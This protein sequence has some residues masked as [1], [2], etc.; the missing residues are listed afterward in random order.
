MEAMNALSSIKWESDIGFSWSDGASGIVSIGW[1]DAWELSGDSDFQTKIKKYNSDDCVAL[2]RVVDFI[3]RL[4]DSNGKPT[5]ID[6]K[7]V[8]SSEE[9]RWRSTYKWGNSSFLVPEFDQ[10]NKCA[11]FDYQSTRISFGKRKKLHK[12]PLYEWWRQ[13]MGYKV[14]R[15]KTKMSK[16]KMSILLLLWKI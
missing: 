2:A 8:G 4:S 3:R 1:R 6:G 9:I 16:W 7:S 10:I 14:S 12:P 5:N 11:Y 13:K 15:V